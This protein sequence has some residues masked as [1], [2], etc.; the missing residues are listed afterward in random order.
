MLS[1]G[2]CTTPSHETTSHYIIY[3]RNKRKA[4]SQKGIIMKKQYFVNLIDRIVEV[5]K[6]FIEKA[7]QL[8]TEENALYDRLLGK[9]P[10]FKFEVKDLN[11]SNKQTYKGLRIEVMQAFI[12]QHEETPE[13]YNPQLKELNKAMAEGLMKDAK[14]SV[15]K[16]WF[17]KHYGEVFNGSALSKKEGKQEELIKNLLALANKNE[18]APTAATEQ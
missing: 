5:D 13:K 16:S 2:K 11:K 7:G 4:T 9:Y 15:A 6:K 1:Q 12:I 14:Y 18:N 17:L 3:K 8:D 10:S